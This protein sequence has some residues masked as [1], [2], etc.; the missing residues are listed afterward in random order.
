M[1]EILVLAALS[2]AACGAETVDETQKCDAPTDLQV[3]VEDA[4]IVTWSYKPTCGV[5]NFAIEHDGKALGETKEMSFRDPTY[6]LAEWRKC[7]AGGHNGGG[8]F[9]YRVTAI[10]AVGRMTSKVSDWGFA[11]AWSSSSNP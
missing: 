6:D 7:Q 9:L 2:C 3:R 5:A 8:K 11:C 10:T 4:P 1:R